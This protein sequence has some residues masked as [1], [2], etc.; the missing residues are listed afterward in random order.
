MAARTSCPPPSGAA[1]RQYMTPA[2]IVKKRRAA[3]RYISRILGSWPPLPDEDRRA[4]A[5]LLLPDES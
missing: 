4:L 5:A 2:H 1:G 3:E